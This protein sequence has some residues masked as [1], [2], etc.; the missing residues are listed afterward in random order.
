[1]ALER[2]GGAAARTT[3]G[4]PGVPP[5]APPLKPDVVLFGELLPER[6]LAEAQALALDADLMVC[7]GSSLEVY[8]VAGLPAITRGAAAGWRWSPRARPPTTTTPRS[9]SAA[10]W[11]RSC[12]PCSPR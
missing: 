6:A 12:G 9:S 7:V 1:M 4:A 2:R 10:T 8:P 3:D 11:S 5:A